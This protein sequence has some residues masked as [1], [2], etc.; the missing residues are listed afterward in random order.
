MLQH[1]KVPLIFRCGL[2]VYKMDFV[3]K[4]CLCGLYSGALSLKTDDDRLQPMPSVGTLANFCRTHSTGH[5]KAQLKFCVYKLFKDWM[6]EP[7][8]FLKKKTTKHINKD[9]R[10]CT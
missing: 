6:E 8:I 4:I 7:Q 10:K 9:Q 2:Y 5:A 3:L 1:K